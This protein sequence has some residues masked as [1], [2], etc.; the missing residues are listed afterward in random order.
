MQIMQESRTES[1]LLC[2]DLVQME[3]RLTDGTLHREN[4]NLE[5]ISVSGACLQLETAVPV[6]SVIR[7]IHEK[8]NLIG[9]VRY[10]TFRDVGY[11]VGVQFNPTSKWSTRM[12]RPLHLLAPHRFQQADQPETVSH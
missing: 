2:A 3:W 4:A 1:R 10:C 8:G 12:F 5:D 9:K 7:L 11:F 6:G